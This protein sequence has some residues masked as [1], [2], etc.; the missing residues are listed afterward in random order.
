MF[1]LCVQ[2]FTKS[3]GGPDSRVL[4][5]FSSVRARSLGSGLLCPMVWT[6]S[7]LCPGIWSPSSSKLSSFLTKMCVARDFRCAAS[8]SHS[9]ARDARLLP[10]RLFEQLKVAL[11]KLDLSMFSSHLIDVFYVTDRFWKEKFAQGSWT[12]RLINRPANQ[13]ESLPTQLSDF[14]HMWEQDG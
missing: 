11:W 2:L 8:V 3:V 7:T 13:L 5:V 14:T 1:I 4:Q 10:R 6:M 12:V 9:A